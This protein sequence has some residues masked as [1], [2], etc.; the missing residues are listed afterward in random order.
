MGWGAAKVRLQLSEQ[1]TA[2]P[3]V[4]ASL[5]T[6]H[7]LQNRKAYMMRTMPGGWEIKNFADFNGWASSRL[8]N[9]RDKFSLS[10]IPTTRQWMI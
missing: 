9:T 3:K 6:T 10:S 4:V 2:Q 5:P 1:F 8:C 7:Q